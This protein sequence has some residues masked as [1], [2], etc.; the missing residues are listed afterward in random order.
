[1]LQFSDKNNLQR[2]LEFGL[3]FLMDYNEDRQVTYDRVT[4]KKEIGLVNT[5]IESDQSHHAL[6]Y[7]DTIGI[8]PW[9]L[10][11]LF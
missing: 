2:E 1:M 8:K 4:K 10:K 5:I 9:T 6:I 11:L 7:L 3:T